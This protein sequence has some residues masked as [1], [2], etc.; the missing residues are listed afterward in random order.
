VLLH[1]SRHLSTWL[2]FNVGQMNTMTRYLGPAC[3]SG[4]FLAGL[5]MTKGPTSVIPIPRTD[6]SASNLRYLYR[7]P[8]GRILYVVVEEKGVYVGD[9]VVPFD[10]FDS[11]LKEEIK[12]F[13]PDGAIVYG[14]D[15]ARYAEVVRV[16]TSVSKQLPGYATLDTFSHAVGTRRGPIEIHEHSWEY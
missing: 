8:G 3:V 11:F 9:V 16:Y 14:T 4:V 2:I 1:E 15:L 12:I 6:H 13:K 10:A 7:L 5:L